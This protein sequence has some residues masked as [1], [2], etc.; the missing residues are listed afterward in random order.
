M[1]KNFILC[2]VY[3]VYNHNHLKHLNLYMPLVLYGFETWSV[4][5]REEYRPRVFENRALRKVFRPNRVEV[6]GG[7]TK[8][9]NLRVCS[10][11][12]GSGWANLNNINHCEYLGVGGKM[13]LNRFERKRMDFIWFG[14]GTSQY[15]N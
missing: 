7:W 8:L 4:T 1:L 14:L 5:L 10:V 11:H 2:D 15:G 13:M 9:C 3:A 12:T 6:A